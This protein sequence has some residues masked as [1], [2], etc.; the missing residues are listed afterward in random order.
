MEGDVEGEHT[1][2][3]RVVHAVECVSWPFVCVSAC[4]KDGFVWRILTLR[5]DY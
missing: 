2:Y 3:E 1:P 5:C 4:I